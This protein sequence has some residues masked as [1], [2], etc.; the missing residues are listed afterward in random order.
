MIDKNKNLKRR[1]DEMNR[2]AILQQN[3]HDRLLTDF[4]SLY[5]RN[6]NDKQ[7]AIK[8]N[9]LNF[10]M[11]ERFKIANVSYFYFD[12]SENH[13][14]NMIVFF[15]REIIYKEMF[16]FTNRVKNYATTLIELKILTNLLSCFREI[17]LI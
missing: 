12:M 8:Q 5:N 9:A 13:E 17:A 7:F 16:V 2:N 10:A 6:L 15:S 3:L 4:I 1:I 14:T 11:I